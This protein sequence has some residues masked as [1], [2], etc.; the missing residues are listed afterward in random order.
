MPYLKKY[1]LDF[2]LRDPKA[3]REY[4]KYINSRVRAARGNDLGKLRDEI[5]GLIQLMPEYA[6]NRVPFIEKR[7]RGFNHELTACLLCPMRFMAQ[8][9]ANPAEFCSR[10]KDGEV[11]MVS[12]DF[13][14][15]LYD[16]SMYVGAGDYLSGFC[17]GPLLVKVFQW[18]FCRKK[19]AKGLLKYG[20]RTSGKKPFLTKYKIT[21]V[22][23]CMIAYAAVLLCFVLN[24]QEHWSRKDGAFDLPELHYNVK[25]SFGMRDWAKETLAWWNEQIFGA[26]SG[27]LHVTRRRRDGPRPDSMAARIASMIAAQLPEEAN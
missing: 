25:M 4:G 20:E 9:D 23:P 22:T 6:A 27:S 5:F 13:L 24:D 19:V 10:V 26:A 11:E 12:D 7:E 17:R 16:T 1:D 8:F 2:L 14:S 15:A 21:E 18:L 3:L